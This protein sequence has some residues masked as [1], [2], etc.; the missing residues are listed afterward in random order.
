MSEGKIV[1]VIC[2]GHHH[3]DSGMFWTGYKDKCHQW[4]RRV[5]DAIQFVTF[6]GAKAAGVSAPNTPYKDHS[7]YPDK[8]VLVLPHNPNLVPK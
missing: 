2:I 6:D 8:G 1:F 4:S 7:E 3:P 5:Q